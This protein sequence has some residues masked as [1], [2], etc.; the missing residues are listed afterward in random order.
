MG[1]GVVG[2]GRGGTRGGQREWAY[3]LSG[4]PAEKGRGGCRGGE[5]VV[6][7]AGER[8]RA[9]GGWKG[10]GVGTGWPLERG[11]A[12]CFRLEGRL[13]GVV[14]NLRGGG[15][16][17]Q[18]GVSR[19]PEGAGAGKGRRR[20]PGGFGLGG[21]RRSGG[22]DVG[23]RPGGSVGVGGVG[24]GAGEGGVGPRWAREGV[25]GVGARLGPLLR[26]G[27]GWG[28]VGG[29]AEWGQGAPRWRVLMGPR[30]AGGGDWTGGCL[31]ARRLASRRRGEGALGGVEAAEGEG[32]VGGG[33]EG[34]CRGFRAWLPCPVTPAPGG[35]EESGGWIIGAEGRGGAGGMG[36]ASSTGGAVDSLG[37]RGGVK[38]GSG[39]S[40]GGGGGGRSL[41]VAGKKRGGGGGGFWRWNGRWAKERVAAQRV[42]YVA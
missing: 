30:A 35:R 19:G 10:L 20:D 25:R 27:S 2:E 40:R 23:G 34:S 9:G 32:R 16:A 37:S 21:A 22:R 28:G 7:W 24:E 13:Q 39:F 14:K 33:M 1:M 3:D 11:W 4:F 5:G 31:R 29:E 18:E 26:R 41:G 17:K 38:V 12:W 36:G 8:D 42:G 15:W 6:S